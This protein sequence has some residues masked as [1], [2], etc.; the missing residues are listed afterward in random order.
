M[1]R[2]ARC[3]AIAGLVLTLMVGGALRAHAQ[4]HRDS[5]LVI[6]TPNGDYACCLNIRVYNRQVDTTLTIS[7]FRMRVISGR[8]TLQQGLTNPPGRWSVASQTATS[9]EWTSN[10]AAADIVHGASLSGFQVCVA[11]T[12]ICRMVWETRNLDSAITRDTITFACKRQGCDEAFFRIV[13]SAFRSVIDVDVVAG[14][15]TG[16]LINDFHVH[17]VTPGVQLN[18]A[19]TPLPTGWIRNRI[20]PDTLGFFTA[21]NALDFDQFV[22]GIRIEL[23]S[24]NTDSTVQLEWW[25]TNFG[26]VICLDT[27]RLKFGLTRRDSLNRAGDVR[28]GGSDCCIDLAFQNSHVPASVID[29]LTIKL[30]SPGA[31]IDSLPLAAAPWTVRGIG[32][33]SIVIRRTGGIQIGDTALLSRLCVDNSHGTSDSVRLHWYTFSR[34]LVVTSSTTSFRCFR[35]LTACDSVSA[36]VDSS[37]APSSRCVQMTVRNR[38]NRR[39]PITRVAVKISNVGT[40]RTVLS[41]VAPSPWRIV[42]AAGDSAVFTGGSIVAGGQ[43]GPFTFCVSAGDASTRDPLVLAWTTDHNPGGACGDTIRLGAIVGGTCDTVFAQP[44][45]SPNDSTACFHVTVGNNNSGHRTIDRVRFELP[46]TANVIITSANVPAPWQVATQSFPSFDLD[47][48]GPGV[49]TG[50]TLAP[51]DLCFDME[52]IHTYPY[53]IK[54]LWRTIG[55]GSQ[56]CSDTLVLVV[57]GAGTL[58]DSM[59]KQLLDGAPLDECK[60]AYRVVNLHNGPAGPIDGVRFRTVGTVG[61]IGSVTTSDAASTW[62]VA[63]QSNTDVIMRGPAIPPGGSLENFIV[64][65]GGG[66]VPFTF[67]TST[68]NG[69]VT[70]CSSRENLFCGD[71]SVSRTIAPTGFALHEPQPNPAA[72]SVGVPYTLLRAADA[73][74]VLRDLSGR[75]LLRIGQGHQEAGEH[76]ATLSLE[77]IPSGT[78]YVTLEAGGE[79]DSRRLVVVR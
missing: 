9:V 79:L 38:N 48:N 15:G 64:V 2:F 10:A 3:A 62:G 68:L 70:I 12:G 36:V 56:V 35:L 67:E 55:N 42:S 6:K 77:R 7:D 18:T 25:T 71:L 51:I 17:P 49:V 23:D 52:L 29:S 40:P 53:S 57:P 28:A 69:D 41:A 33:D 20:K 75:E 39:D 30:A 46:P 58:C 50:G 16:R 45:Q 37:G 21:T 1:N 13:P 44:G 74:V 47:I 59:P 4:V 73:V 61:F 22:E 19:A 63:Q 24:V 76:R 32:T 78:Y 14:N 11:D 34:G 66:G 72:T 26:D 31:T 54:L 8:A 27:A 65:C 43:A 5:L 60:F